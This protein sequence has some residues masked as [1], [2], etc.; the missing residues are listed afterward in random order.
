MMQSG[1]EAIASATGAPTAASAMG[2]PTTAS[3]MDA[4]TTWSTTALQ[5]GLRS[6]DTAAA[7]SGFAQ[8][9]LA[10]L[11]DVNTDVRSAEAQMRDLA[12][13]KA[14]QLHDVMISLERAQLSVQTFVQIRNKLVESYQDLMRMQL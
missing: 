10:G 13:G 9:M 11:N 5:A 6:A 4:P 7:P 12:S 2:A 8:H 14:V 3:V 1:I